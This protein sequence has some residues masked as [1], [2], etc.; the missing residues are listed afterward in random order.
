MRRIAV[1]GNL[2]ALS[3]FHR[4]RSTVPQFDNDLAAEQIEHVAEVAPVVGEIARPIFDHPNTQ[5][6]HRRG[7]GKTAPGRSRRNRR[8]QL[9]KFG[10]REGR[11]RDF[12]ALDQGLKWISRAARVGDAPANPYTLF[13]AMLKHVRLRRL[14]VTTVCVRIHDAIS[15]ARRL[16]R[17]DAGERPHHA[18]AAFALEFEPGI[19][20]RTNFALF[21]VIATSRFQ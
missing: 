14:Q 11:R 13:T 6:A 18:I 16:C 8:G 17:A 15:R 9:G 1:V 3:C 12:H 7:S 2:E 4:E 20:S 10:D 21:G 19:K 5:I